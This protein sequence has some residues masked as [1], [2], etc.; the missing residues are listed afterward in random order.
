MTKLK[1]W[2]KRKVAGK[3]NPEKRCFYAPG[4]FSL[5]LLLLMGLGIG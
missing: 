1:H 5:F 4:G 2:M 3:W